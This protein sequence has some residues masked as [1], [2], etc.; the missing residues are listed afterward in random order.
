MGV[1]SILGPPAFLI[2]INDLRGASHIDIYYKKRHCDV[3]L[4]PL[5]TPTKIS[6][7]RGLFPSAV[8]RMC[9]KFKIE[10]VKKQQSAALYEYLCG[11]DAFVNIPTV[12]EKSLIVKK[13]SLIACDLAIF[14]P[15]RAVQLIGSVSSRCKTLYGNL[16]YSDDGFRLGCRN[17]SQHQQQSF[18]GLHYKPGQSL[19]P[20]H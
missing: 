4:N 10:I 11:K 18:S 2:Y 5:P 6:F 16:D 8:G 1:K 12:Y 17:V 19:K 3:S 9:R 15:S 13:V 7:D 20:Q 14:K